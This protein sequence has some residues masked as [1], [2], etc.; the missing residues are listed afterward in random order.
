MREDEREEKRGKRSM[1]TEGKWRKERKEMK[2]R[3]DG[4]KERRREKGRGGE[5]ERRE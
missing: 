3:E 1:Y 4:R 5:R 2:R